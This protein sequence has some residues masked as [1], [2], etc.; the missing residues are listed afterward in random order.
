MKGLRVGGVCC[1]VGG[2]GGGVG[3]GLC[4]F[5][6][7]SCAVFWCLY[8]LVCPS[9]SSSDPCL[10]LFKCFSS[11]SQ[12]FHFHTK[13]KATSFQCLPFFNVYLFL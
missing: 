8:L 9:V 1:C 2:G 5:V 10:S 4:P 7:C 11:K 3:K 12:Q 6:P 13:L